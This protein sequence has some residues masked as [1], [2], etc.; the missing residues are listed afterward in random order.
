MET[1]IRSIITMN[2]NFIRPNLILG[3]IL[4]S[5][6]FTACNQQ[7]LMDE[8]LAVDDEGWDFRNRARFEVLVE[9]TISLHAF[10]LNVRQKETY[11]YNNLYVFLHTTFPNGTLTHD[12]IECLLAQPDG[13]WLGKTSGSYI[14]NQILL[15]ESLRFPLAGQYRFEIEQAMREEKLHGIA[16]IGIRIETLK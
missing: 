6:I 2:N 4:F 14:S 3:A 10:Y 13:K 8:N 12:T 11:R 5:L 16:D 9:D 1:A 7:V 15:N